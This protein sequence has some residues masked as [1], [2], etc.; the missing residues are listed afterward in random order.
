MATIITKHFTHTSKAKVRN[1]QSNSSKKLLTAFVFGLFGIIS[2]LL[3]SPAQAQ[4]V[5][6]KADKPPQLK[7]YRQPDNIPATAGVEIKQFVQN[8]PHEGSAPSYATKA[9]LSYDQENLYTIFVA[10][11]NPKHL[12]ARHSRRENNGGEDFVLLQID[13]FKDAQRAF[14][15]Y[16]TP[17]GVQADASYIEGKEE[18]FDFDTQWHTEGELTEFG[19]IVKIAIPFKSLRFANGDKQEWGLSVA[20][21]IPEF[22]EFITWPL[23]S[24]R[25]P[26]LVNQFGTVVI[27]ER[28][29]EQR[30][31]H[32]NPYLFSGKD[33]F[34]TTIDKQGKKY[35]GFVQQQKTQLGLDAKYVWNNSVTVDLTLNPDFSDVESDEPQVLVDKRFETLF[36]EKRPFFLENSGFFK[37]PL[38]L[39]FSRRIVEPDAG[40]RVTGRQN[41]FALGGMIMDDV[42]EPA[43]GKAHIGL[44]RGQVDFGQT[45]NLGLLFS[46]RSQADQA[47]SVAGADF[48]LTPVA[49]WIFTGQFAKSQSKQHQSNHENENQNNK[50]TNN[51]DHLAYVEAIYGSRALTYSGKYTD[52]GQQFDARLGFIPR[53]DIKQN[54]QQANYTWFGAPGDW[55]LTQELKAT[56]THTDNQQGQFQDQKN[57]LLYTLKAKQANTFTIEAVQQ[58]DNLN[59]QKVK[60][61]G[62]LLGWHTRTLPELVS[63]IKLGQRQAPNYQFV[64]PAVLSG[65]ARNAQLKIKWLLGRHVRLDASYIWNDLRH[66]KGSIYLDR[67]AR[68]NLA[69]QFDNY[70]G[71]SLIMDYHSLSANQTWSSLKNEKSLNT[72]L[73]LRYVLSPGSSVYLGYVDRQENIGLFHDEHGLVQARPTNQLSLH[74]G[75]RV[76]IKLSHLF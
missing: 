67:L 40:L 70:W 23:I 60:T 51:N 73:Q 69:Y 7:D 59:N 34:L 12:I 71:A 53:T 50:Q 63:T 57:H 17:L 5:I 58:S 27:N 55:I 14:V 65:D 28:I 16:V 66:A 37:T 10:H 75:K 41:Q 31:Y 33:K 20:R 52:I 21:Y 43:T 74:T 26:T 46:K 18:D 38:P 76:F 36:P 6:P 8:T 30:N 1:R 72:N 13:T 39:F 48:R 11:A 32:I 19:Y 49:N 4:L 42:S 62:W 9:Y 3:Q 35:A 47:N 22:T 68:F 56:L 25:Q 44:V 15:F 2:L 45:G 61:A 29:P 24:K 64:D 54:E